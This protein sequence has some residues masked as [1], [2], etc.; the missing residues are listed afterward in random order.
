MSSRRK[1]RSG[2]PTVPLVGRCSTFSCRGAALTPTNEQHCQGCNCGQCEGEANP[3]NGVSRRSRGPRSW[4][5][6][7]RFDIGFGR[8][9]RSSLSRNDEPSIDEIAESDP[10]S[11]PAL[12]RGAN[13]N[14]IAAVRYSW[15]DESNRHAVRVPDLGPV[16]NLVPDSQ[17]PD[18]YRTTGQVPEPQRLAAADEV[19]RERSVL[20][21]SA[22]WPGLHQCVGDGPIAGGVL[23]FVE[24][25]L[26]T[27]GRCEP[28]DKEH[29]CRRDRQ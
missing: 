9:S 19:H 23:L 15:H 14:R 7:D 20:W 16:R 22:A 2:A 25:Q 27:L 12:G 29:C 3:G 5:L 24:S 1:R 4:T 11:L 26:R 8:R 21:L 6:R 13:P 17:L 28:R 10:A 18:R